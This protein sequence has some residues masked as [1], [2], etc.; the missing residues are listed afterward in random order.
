MLAFENFTHEKLWDSTPPFVQQTAKLQAEI[1]AL[2]AQIAQD[3]PGEHQIVQTKEKAID[4]KERTRQLGLYESDARTIDEFDRSQNPSP[5]LI[6]KAAA[7]L[8]DM[9]AVAQAIPDLINSIPDVSS[10]I[11][12]AKA[13][14]TKMADMQ[15]QINALQSIGSR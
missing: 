8:R 10:I 13:A 6:R 7:A 1:D 15:R 11:S 14:Q 2:N 4:E 5:E 3:R 12:E 9:Q